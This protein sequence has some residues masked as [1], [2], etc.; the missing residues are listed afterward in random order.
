LYLPKLKWKYNKKYINKYYDIN[1]EIN[2]TYF[3]E[4]T[5]IDN[6][7]DLSISNS[8]ILNKNLLKKCIIENQIISS[9]NSILKNK[10]V[11]TNEK[12][13]CSFTDSFSTEFIINKLIKLKKENL[14]KSVPDNK[15]NN[16]ISL[17]ENY[18]WPLKNFLKKSFLAS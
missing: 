3:E 17:E 6:E 1:Y 7:N 12:I 15:K 8:I 11:N 2:D 14:N 13:F 10:I 4:N 16:F 9:E 18:T 5:Y